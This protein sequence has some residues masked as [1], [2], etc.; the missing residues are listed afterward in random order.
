MEEDDEPRLVLA[1]WIELGENAADH[2][3]AISR[4]MSLRPEDYQWFTGMDNP[5]QFP[6][7]DCEAISF[8]D[9][10][11]ASTDIR[12]PDSNDP[13][14]GDRSSGTDDSRPSFG[15]G[16][17]ESTGPSNST[18]SG[19]NANN[20]S[21]AGGSAK[22]PTDAP[23][24][25]TST[26]HVKAGDKVDVVFECLDKTVGISVPNN[27]KES[28]IQRIVANTLQVNLTGYWV[29]TVTNGLAQ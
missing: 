23:D 19:T 22:G 27:I 9:P 4:K 24:Y 16:S 5:L 25:T 14:P 17:E 18:S 26:V 15:P 3:D 28:M 11:R 1:K 6:W 10:P 29:A 21:N 2:W 13:E 8:H 20:S 7:Y 12:Q